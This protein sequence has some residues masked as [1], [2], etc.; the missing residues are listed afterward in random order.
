MNMQ[1]I[2]NNCPVIIQNILCSMYGAKI[3]QLRHQKKYRYLFQNLMESSNWSSTQIE[4][5]QNESFLIILKYAYDNFQYFRMKYNEYGVDMSSIK[6]LRDIKKLPIMTKLDMREISVESPANIDRVTI[7][8]SGST[9]T[10][11]SFYTDFEALNMYYA[12]WKRYKLRF[13]ITN[14]S[15]KI[16]FGGKMVAPIKQNSPPFWRYNAFSNQLYFSTQHISEKNIPA[17]IEKMI[18]FDPEEIFSYPSALN[19]IARFSDKI[20]IPSLKLI[21]LTCENVLDSQRSMIEKKFG[22]KVFSTYGLA[23]PI[24]FFDECE[25][26]NMHHNYEFGCFEVIDQA[27]KESNEGEIILTGFFNKIMPFIRYQSGDVGVKGEHQCAC[28]QKSDYFKSIDG[29]IEDYVLT[30]DGNQVGRMSHIFKGK[31]IDVIESQFVQSSLNE[32]DVYIVPGKKYT[33]VSTQIIL[34]NLKERLG[35][36]MSFNIHYTKEIPRTK[37]GKIRAVISK[38]KNSKVI[39]A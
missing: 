5:F 16:T 33:D 29:R 18:S 8:T 11:L 26:G 35:E 19:V 13:G 3:Y 21:T 31:E 17:I 25:L 14:R 6:D 38:I 4:E 12:L 36:K 10:P 2:Y 9:G 27:G 23:E 24:A 1:K 28:G 22:C 37:S 15:R 34:S 20:E 30:P 7:N 32:L 39:S